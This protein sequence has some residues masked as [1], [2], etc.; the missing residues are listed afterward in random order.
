MKKLLLILPLIF[1]V[2]VSAVLT[3]HMAASTPFDQNDLIDDFT[4]NNIN[5]MPSGTIDNWLNSNF[6]SSCIS[7]NANANGNSGFTTPDPEGWSNTLNQYAFGSNVSAGTAIDDA[8]NLYDINPQVI[9]ATLQKEQSII[10]GGGGCYY[11]SPSPVWPYSGSPAP[12]TTFTCTMNGVATTCTYAC[13][14]SGGCMD[15]AMSYG[16]PYYCSAKDEGFSMQLTLGSW[17]LR[18]GQERAYGILTGY[19]GYETGDENFTY[20]GP[21]TA[22]WRQ[23]VAGGSSV[24]YDGTYTTSDGTSVDINNGATASL[25]N[26]TPYISGNENFDNL[27]QGPLSSGDLGFGTV[28]ANDTFTPHPNGTLVTWGGKVYLINNGTRQWITNGYVFSSYGYQWSQV[29]NAST[30][31]LDLPLGSDISALAPGTV[32]M[33]PG[34]SIVYVMDDS[35]GTLEKQWLSYGS[36][37]ALGY[38]W[39]GIDSIPAWLSA[40]IP[41][42]PGLYTSTRHPDGTLVIPYGVGMIYLMTINGRSH[43]L[44]PLAFETNDYGYANVMGATLSDID[45]PETTP[46]D[47][48]VGTMLYSGGNI[49]LVDQDAS[50]IL[51]RPVGPWECFDNRLHYSLSNTYTI[52]TTELPLRTGSV[53]T[54]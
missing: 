36:F 22:G 19:T 28:Y 17:L 2:M 53:F 6:S 32:F 11:S 23:R 27:F 9:I 42:E 47:I 48:H 4:F 5:T 45:T 26:Y 30:G 34:D 52:P 50:G 41:T 37:V 54:C 15:I 29:L 46:T 18:F 31:D 3:A 33:S 40:S 43:I 24:Y 35:S 16:C 44:S 13:T 51:I 14:Y 8:S 12:N 21:M 7:L 20:Y 49:Y 25:Y 38:S 1:V 39:S 10:S